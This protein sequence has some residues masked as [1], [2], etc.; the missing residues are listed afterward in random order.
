MLLNL[1]SDVPFILDK[2]HYFF[3][4]R[5]NLENL[6]PNFFS[7]LKKFPPDI[8]VITGPGYFSSTRIW[9]EVINILSFLGKFKV[10]YWLD[11]ISL[12]QQFL[13]QNDLEVIYLFSGNKRIFIKTLSDS[14][15]LI[16]KCEN[17][18][19]EFFSGIVSNKDIISYNKVLENYK[20]YN[21][22]KS[23]YIRPFYVFQPIVG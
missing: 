8:F 3:F 11:K 17:P 23:N 16:N 7:R 20:S 19:E 15:E 22:N 6:L 9:V 21:W 5:K 4:D 14:Y 12:F 2:W 13:N 10:I 18:S 1:A